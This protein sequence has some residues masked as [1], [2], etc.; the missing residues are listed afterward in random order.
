MI[1]IRQWEMRSP[2]EPLVL[3][4]RQVAAVPE[5]HAVVRVAGC[6]VCHTDIGFYGGEVRTNHPL[7]LVLG[8]EIS[9]VVQAAGAGA[10]AWIGRQVIV[11]AI[12]PCG[13]CRSCARGR[14]ALCGAQVFPGNDVHGGFASHT[15][16]PARHLCDA[17]DVPA[18]DLWLM[19]VV[20]DAV[21]T[22]YEA[23]SRADLKEGDLAI[24]V[25]AGGVG[26]FGVQ[27]A[28]ALGAHVVAIDPD[29]TRRGL[30]AGHGAGLTLDPKSSDIPA[31]RKSIKAFAA[32]RG[33]DAQEWKIFETSGTTAGQEVAFSLLTRGSHLGV[34]GFTGQKLLLQLSR[35]MALDARAEGNWGCAPGRYPGLLGMIRSGKIAIRPFVERR[36]MSQVNMVLAEMME[37]RLHRRAILVPDFPEAESWAGGTHGA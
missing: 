8:H 24:F 20:A 7:P 4:Q 2:R 10:G 16:V 6:G 19:S 22:P 35:L 33:V 9:G 26:G 3:A 31:L 30:A 5:G 21:S 12:L 27:I 15:V 17:T 1:T 13:V 25:G 28:A 36:P 32:T 37:H 29:E 14:Y 18:D 11:P 23:V 34:V